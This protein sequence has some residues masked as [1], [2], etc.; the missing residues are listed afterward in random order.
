MALLKVTVKGVVDQVLTLEFEKWIGK[1]HRVRTLKS[2]FE[3]V[4]FKN[5]G[6]F[7]HLNSA[8]RTKGCTWPSLYS[9]SFLFSRTFNSVVAMS[10]IS[11]T[12]SCQTEKLQE[13]PYVYASPSFLQAGFT[14]Q[15]LK[16]WGVAITIEIGNCDNFFV[17]SFTIGHWGFCFR[18][19][20]IYLK[21]VDFSN[22]EGF[23]YFAALLQTIRIW[24]FL[25][26]L[27]V[28]RLVPKYIDAIV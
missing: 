17:I 14:V 21:R 15:V 1:V 28:C 7:C 10:Q 11:S 2:F 22:I 18:K 5:F 23:S 6:R 26:H 19:G 25:I 16:L 3:S 12:I 20:S 27:R 4:I 13:I 9:S 8:S 24:L